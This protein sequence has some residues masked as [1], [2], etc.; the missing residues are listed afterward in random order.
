V[1]TGGKGGNLAGHKPRGA[2]F[3]VKSKGIGPAVCA[4]VCLKQLGLRDLQVLG[5]L[6]NR[7]AKGKGKV[8][9]AKGNIIQKTV[10]ADPLK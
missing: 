1:L 9:Q 3:G 4:V 5:S 10:R 7:E 6:H 8:Q 2:M